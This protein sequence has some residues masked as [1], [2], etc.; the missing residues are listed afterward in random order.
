MS[1]TL[2]QPD[3]LCSNNKLYLYLPHITFSCGFPA[4]FVYTGSLDEL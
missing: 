1:K 4:I 2:S 3:S